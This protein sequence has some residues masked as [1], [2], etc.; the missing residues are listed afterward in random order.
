[1]IRDKFNTKGLGNRVKDQETIQNTKKQYEKVTDTGTF[2]YQLFVKKHLIFLHHPILR[3]PPE[4]LHQLGILYTS[5][6]STA[7]TFLHLCLAAKNGRQPQKWKMTLKMEDNLKNGRQP[8]KWKTTT[9]IED[10]LKNG[11]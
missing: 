3:S 6:A 10:D 7:S 8:Q 1:M 9:K 5:S 11:R 2:G 4:F